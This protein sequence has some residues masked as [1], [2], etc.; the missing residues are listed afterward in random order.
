VDVLLIFSSDLQGT[1]ASPK[2][3]WVGQPVRGHTIFS[4][5]RFAGLSDVSTVFYPASMRQRA[6]AVLWQGIHD[7]MA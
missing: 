2:G 4:A 3:D 5:H 6:A 1:R 7:Y